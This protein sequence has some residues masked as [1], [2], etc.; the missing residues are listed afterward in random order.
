L[1]LLGQLAGRHVP[2]SDAEAAMIQRI[3]RKAGPWGRRPTEAG[4]ALIGQQLGPG[5]PV[6][7]YLDAL[8][9]RVVTSNKNDKNP[10]P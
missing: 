7:T 8:L 3:Y 9:A 5:R 10:K 2:Q 6:K 4:V 1:A